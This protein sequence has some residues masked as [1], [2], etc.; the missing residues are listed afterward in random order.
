MDSLTCHNSFQN[1]NNGKATVL[2]PDVQFL[3]CNKFWN[4][5]I[6]AWVGAPQNL[7]GDYFFKA[8]KSSFEN[9]AIVTF[10]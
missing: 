5:I 7:L 3:S 2:L 4:S 10:E 8:R 1:E 6:S 9:V